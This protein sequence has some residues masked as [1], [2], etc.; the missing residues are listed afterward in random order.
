MTVMM[1]HGDAFT[2]IL[3]PFKEVYK[4]NADMYLSSVV[5]FARQF[6]V[7]NGLVVKVKTVTLHVNRHRWEERL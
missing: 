7:N 4:I 6:S 3:L 5:I 2:S 1:K